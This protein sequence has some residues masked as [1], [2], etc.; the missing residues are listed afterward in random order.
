MHMQKYGQEEDQRNGQELMVD[1][2]WNHGV[3]VIC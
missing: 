1:G 3:A 2:M